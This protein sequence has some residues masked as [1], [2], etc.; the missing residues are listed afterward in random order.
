MKIEKREYVVLDTGT[1]TATIKAIEL[2]ESTYE[3]KTSPRLTWKFVLDDGTE[4]W[5]WTGTYLGGPKATLTKWATNLYGKVPDTLDTDELI[6]KPC[7]LSVV[8]RTKADG[9]ETNKIDNVLAPRAG[10]KARPMPEP[11]TE[12]EAIP[13]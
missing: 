2:G 3:G 9:T 6:G 8:I 7:R 11:E 5:G 4:L 12:D 10:Q 13:F 1:Y